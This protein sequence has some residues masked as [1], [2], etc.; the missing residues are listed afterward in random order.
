[1]MQALTDYLFMDGYWHFVWPAYGATAGVFVALL[2]ASLRSLR[3]N[4]RAASAL[5]RRRSR[6]AHAADDA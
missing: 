6:G 5:E 3:A 4:E 1:M 2:V